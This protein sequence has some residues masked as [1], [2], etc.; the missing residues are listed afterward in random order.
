LPSLG[1]TVKTKNN[2]TNWWKNEK[3]YYPPWSDLDS[4][5]FEGGVTIFWDINDV[6]D[7]LTQY[8][9]YAQYDPEIGSF[10][11]SPLRVDYE[12]KDSLNTKI[13]RLAS[14]EIVNKDLLKLTGWMDN[15]SLPD[16]DA[17]SIYRFK[18]NSTAF[19]PYWVDMNELSNKEYWN[20]MR[21][22]V[23]YFVKNNA[24]HEDSLLAYLK[25]CY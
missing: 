15:V 21:P 3:C 9:N 10:G 17:V 8:N 12:L 4:S 5:V 11:L 19:I 25:V 2:T 18:K 24:F 16:I 7:Y 14:N 23:D 6:V 1:W 22:G 13:L 20:Y